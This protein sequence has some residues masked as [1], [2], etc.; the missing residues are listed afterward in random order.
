MSIN[1]PTL[2]QSN[3]PLTPD[4]QRILNRI[5][6]YTE[7]TI[8]IREEGTL[9]KQKIEDTSLRINKLTEA[10]KE[11]NALSFIKKIIWK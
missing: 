9:L 7:Q 3:C 8:L 5:D 4:T 6:R 11:Q 2:N 1:P 10:K